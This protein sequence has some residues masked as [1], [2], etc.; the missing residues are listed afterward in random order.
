MHESHRP[1]VTPIDKKGG[2]RCIILRRGGA[3][4]LMFDP[5][6]NCSNFAPLQT[7]KE[8]NMV[9]KQP[10]GIMERKI[11]FMVG[12]QF[13]EGATTKSRF[14]IS[15]IFFIIILRRRNAYELYRNVK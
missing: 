12:K 8:N 4:Q 3:D 9:N 10:A 7:A 2:E 13:V 14:C 6:V 11:W 15:L 1:A 5:S